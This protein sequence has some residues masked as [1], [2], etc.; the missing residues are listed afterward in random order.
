MLT[1]RDVGRPGSPLS[2]HIGCGRDYVRGVDGST[3]MLGLTWSLPI[4]DR[5]SRSGR[6]REG[7]PKP[8]RLANIVPKNNHSITYLNTA[9]SDV[10]WG[11]ER[12]SLL[13]FFFFFN[14]FLS[15]F[16]GSGDVY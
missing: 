1:G 6:H 3:Q 16:P 9:Y 11:H 4:R 7:K 5:A 12:H 14:I 10:R 13:L 2:R 8:P 15:C